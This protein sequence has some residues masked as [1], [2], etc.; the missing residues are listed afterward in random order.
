M[1]RFL[2]I[3]QKFGFYK[4]KEFAFPHKQ[5]ALMRMKR[6]AWSGVRD[7]PEKAY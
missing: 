3:L 1:S 4:E 7:S 6:E 5:A 2:D